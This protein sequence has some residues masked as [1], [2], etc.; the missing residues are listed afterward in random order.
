MEKEQSNTSHTDTYA[1]F[2]SADLEA[3]NEG[4]IAM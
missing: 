4:F 2:T 3:G 1:T